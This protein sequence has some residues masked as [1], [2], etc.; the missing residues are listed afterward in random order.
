MVDIEKSYVEVLGRR[1][2]F[3]RAGA[4]DPVLLLHGSGPGVSAAA[5]WRLALPA[6]GEHFSVVAP[7]LI[8]FG[9]TEGAP[10]D[11]SVHA[12]AAFVIAFCAALNLGKVH[13]VGNSMG[14]AVAL[15]VAAQR[16]DLVNRLAVMGSVGVSFPITDGLDK[17]WGYTPSLDN[18]RELIGLFAYDSSF[19]GNEQLVAMRYEASKEPVAAARYEALFPAPRQRWVERLSLAVDEL[20][21]IQAPVLLIH[22]KEDR[23]I[24]WEVTSRKLLEVLPDARLHLFAKCGHWVQLERANE[25]HALLRA[26]FSG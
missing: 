7:D 24:P 4:G 17:V 13:V 5:N 26:F 12:W 23:V 2:C 14:G 19:A 15:G 11:S 6:L 25:F 3:L 16:P 21:R 22:G 1:T 18:M 20:E 9:E 10:A 8:G